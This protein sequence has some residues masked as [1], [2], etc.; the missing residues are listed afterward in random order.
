[1]KCKECKD[2]DMIIKALMTANASNA[3]KLEDIGK[4]VN[5]NILTETRVL[6]NENKE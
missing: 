3:I 1:M 5:P 6:S 2:K 4:I